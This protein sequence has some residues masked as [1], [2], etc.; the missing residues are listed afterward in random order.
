MAD[1]ELRR[2]EETAAV[3]R[4]KPQMERE[5]K[6]EASPAWRLAAESDPPT[7]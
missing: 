7:S 1:Q 3:A 6:A 5:P 2:V 4:A